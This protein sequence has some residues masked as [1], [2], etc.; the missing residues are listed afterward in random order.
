MFLNAPQSVR[1]SANS[2]RRDA[3]DQPDRPIDK[4]RTDRAPI[5]EIQ[6]SQSYRKDRKGRNLIRDRNFCLNSSLT[7]RSLREDKKIVSFL[8]KDF[9]ITSL[10]QMN[11]CVCVQ[12]IGERRTCAHISRFL[13]LPKFLHPRCKPLRVKLFFEHIKVC[14]YF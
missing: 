10:A 6:E 13:T 7:V 5:E 4:S 8:L 14:F 12:P 9:L 11:L 2:D 3:D 1:L